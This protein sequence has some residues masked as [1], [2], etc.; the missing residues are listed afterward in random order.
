[1]RILVV[2][3]GGREHA[4]AWKLRQ[5]PRVR[6]VFCAP[7]NGGMGSVATCVPIEAGDL[8]GLLAFAR[9]QAIGLT[10]VGPEAP[11]SAGIVDLFEEHGL[12]VFGA[13]R[14]AAELE[15]SKSFAKEIMRRHGIPTAAARA[16]TDAG[17]ARD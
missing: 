15:G 7:G 4:L 2:G 10:V 12:R 13:S 14:A 17:A 5:S 8:R 3:G 1:M 6:E 11:L 16:I 9:E